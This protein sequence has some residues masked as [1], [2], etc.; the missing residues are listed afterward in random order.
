MERVVLVALGGAVGSVMRYLTTLLATRWLGTEFP[1]GTLAVNIVGSFLIG[2]IHELG[3]EAI[4]LSPEARLFLATGVMGGLTTYSA[5]SYETARLL[6]RQ[7]WAT[8]WTYVVVTT[9]ACVALCFVG[10]AVGR[11]MSR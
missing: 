4:R 9:A 6:E 2:V 3:S 1:W 10:F 8:A 5:F 7:A 11:Y